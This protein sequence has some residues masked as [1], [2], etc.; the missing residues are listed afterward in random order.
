MFSRSYARARVGLPRS[1][2]GSK[3]AVRAWCCALVLILGLAPLSATASDVPPIDDIGTLPLVAG[4]P[5]GASMGSKPE[6]PGGSAPAMSLIFVG[7]PGAM[8]NL[9]Q[10]AAGSGALVWSF[11]AGQVR[12]EVLG[13][14][15]LQLDPQI[16]MSGAV[17][18]FLHVR[19]PL[20]GALG[21][22]TW[23]GLITAPHLLMPG[24]LDLPLGSLASSGAL[25]AD[26]VEFHLV[27]DSMHGEVRLGVE[28]SRVVVRQ[29]AP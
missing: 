29:E 24:K 23:N 26:D 18:S 14:L 27:K 21:T 15:E 12:A 17:S 8:S 7:P 6:E 11:G 25:D 1:G 5:P 2:W 13:D 16:L 20:G 3:G 9:V 28:D 19:R 22:M 4:L 10:A